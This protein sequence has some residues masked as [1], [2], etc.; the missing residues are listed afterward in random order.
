M[1]KVYTAF[2]RPAITREAY[3]LTSSFLLGKDLGDPLV[4]IIEDYFIPA[5]KNG[6][7]TRIDFLPTYYCRAFPLYD[8]TNDTILGKLILKDI[9]SYYKDKAT[10]VEYV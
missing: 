2:N 1:F 8:M 5:R 6:S 10:R 9:Y 7:S 4:S 3:F